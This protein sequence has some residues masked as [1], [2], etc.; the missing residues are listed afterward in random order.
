MEFR[1][2]DEG[3]GRNVDIAPLVVAVDPLAAGEDLPH[4]G[5]GQVFVLP[6]VPYSGIQRHNKYTPIE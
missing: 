6:E 1:Q 3:R 2:F 4:L 5:L